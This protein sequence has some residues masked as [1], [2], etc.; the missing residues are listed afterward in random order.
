GSHPCPNG[1]A[2]G[3]DKKC[4]PAKVTAKEPVE[5]DDEH[6]CKD[7]GASCQNGHCATPPQGGPG[8]TEFPAP[9][10]DFESPELRSET[11]DVLTR[12]ATCITSGSLKGKGVLLTGHCDARGEYEF[13]MGLGAERAERV[14]TFLLTLGVPGSKVST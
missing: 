14:K 8:C 6:P 11:K 10:F 2:C 5:C 9:K 4:G 12:L 1:G 13:N 7:R 3:T